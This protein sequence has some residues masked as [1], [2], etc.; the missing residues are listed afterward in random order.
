MQISSN[1]FHKG[2][3]DKLKDDRYCK[4]NGI[5]NS[6]MNYFETKGAIVSDM[7]DGKLGAEFFT[8]KGPLDRMK[9]LMLMSELGIEPTGSREGNKAAILTAMTEQD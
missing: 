1:F 2:P 6:G 9:D 4:E 5:D 7:T 8:N 3:V